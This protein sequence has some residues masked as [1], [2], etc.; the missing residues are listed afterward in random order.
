M[1][2]EGYNFNAANLLGFIRKAIECREFSKFEFSKVLSNTIEQIATL[3]EQFN[4]PREDLALLDIDSILNAKN[5]RITEIKNFWEKKI[6]ENKQKK[7]FYQQISL[8]PVLSSTRWPTS[9]SSAI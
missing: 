9:L 8:P 1:G 7:E 5:Y 6:E 4:M 2:E 3:G